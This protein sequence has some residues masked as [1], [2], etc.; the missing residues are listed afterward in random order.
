M[1]DRTGEVLEDA[2]N[3]ALKTVRSARDTLERVDADWHPLG[4]VKLVVRLRDMHGVT[5]RLH[6]WHP[7]AF[8]VAP[9]RAHS[10]WFRSTS[11]VLHGTLV[12]TLFE[13]LP[14]DLGQFLIAHSDT[15]KDEHNITIQPSHE[16]VDAR[17]TGIEHYEA[18]ATYI[19]EP[20]QF[21]HAEPMEPDS[22]T[23]SMFI[24]EDVRAPHALSRVLVPP[25]LTVR[26]SHSLDGMPS[27]QLKRVLDD[28]LEALASPQ[29]H[30]A[31]PPK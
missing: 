27:P 3:L 18:G 6:I 21:H 4:F 2:A 13:V 8:L 10:H 9:H 19:V 14:N 22:L 25:S 12:N 1:T 29:Q 11:R 7:F 20:G 5:A 26:E 15:D 31:G 17:T 30:T 28:A 24:E 16:R 23:I